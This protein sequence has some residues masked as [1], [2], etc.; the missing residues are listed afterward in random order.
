MIYLD[1]LRYFYRCWKNKHCFSRISLLNSLLSK[2]NWNLYQCEM[3]LLYV[4]V[5]FKK[6]GQFMLMAQKWLTMLFLIVEVFANSSPFLETFIYFKFI[7]WKISAKTIVIRYS[8]VNQKEVLRHY[9]LSP[10]T[11]AAITLLYSYVYLIWFIEFHKS[12][13]G[14][15][16]WCFLPYLIC[17]I[18]FFKTLV[19]TLRLHAFF[20]SNTF[21]SN[22]RLKLA[23]NQ[24][25][26]FAFFIHAI[27]QKQ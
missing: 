6:S 7:W 27:I 24:A 14:G 9:A 5:K 8:K 25:K 3:C 21:I 1:V 2:A 22:A 10:Q 16:I 4:T 13:S 18:R 23:K 17:R 11:S 12:D 15:K 20:I 26:L 19:Q